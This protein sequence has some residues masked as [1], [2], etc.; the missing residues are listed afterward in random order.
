MPGIYA[1]MHGGCIKLSHVARAVCS[2]VN[3]HYSQ[4]VESSQIIESADAKQQRQQ[5]VSETGASDTCCL[6]E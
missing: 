6:F 4:V 1:N 5:L 2:R 3:L